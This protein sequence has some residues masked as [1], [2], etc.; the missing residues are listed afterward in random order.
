MFR[1]ALL[2]GIGAFIFLLGCRHERMFRTDGD[3]RLAFSTD[4]LRFDTVFTE[5]GS[6]TR[7]LKVYNTYGQF[8]RISSISFA[9]GESTRFR[10]NVDGL[11]GEFF[12]DVEIAPNDSIYVFVEVTI[13]PDQPLSVSPFV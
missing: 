11:P 3:V 1:W 12:E 7:I 6:S 4:T 8:L 2:L 5:L 9:T 13:D 10:M